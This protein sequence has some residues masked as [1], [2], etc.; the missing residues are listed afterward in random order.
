MK[1]KA[2][3][4][5]LAAVLAIS[6]IPVT[7]PAKEVS[8]EN[9]EQREYGVPGED[10]VDGQVIVRLREEPEAMKREK[11]SGSVLDQYETE[12]LIDLENITASRQTSASASARS[13]TGISADEIVLVTGDNTEEMIR[14]LEEDPRVVYAEPNYIMEPYDVPSDPGYEYQWGLKNTLNDASHAT[15]IPAVDMNV[16]EAWSNAGSSSDRPVVAVI[17]SGVDYNHPD[18]KDVMWKDG[19]NYPELT[20]LGGGA[21][22]VNYSG[23]GPTDDPM[24]FLMGHGTHCASI[25][26]AQWNNGQGTAGV[27]SS[28]RIMAL[29]F[30][31]GNSATSNAILCYRYLITAKKAGVNVAVV[32]NSWG[33]GTYDGYMLQSVSDVVTEAGMEGILS[34]FAAGNNYADNDRNTGSIINSPYVVTVG[35]MDSEGYRAGFSN[36]GRQTVD[37]FA[38]GT[39]ILASTTTDTSMYSMENHEMPVQYL[40]WIQDR[41]DSYFYEDFEDADDRV[42]LRLLDEGEKEAERAVP[43]RG[44][45]SSRGLEVSL[46]SIEEGEEFTLEIEFSA[47]DLAAVDPLKELHLAFAG[48]FDGAMKEEV[49]R[50]AQ[51]T[52]EKW[53]LLYST[54]TVNGG[55]YPAYLMVGDSNWNISS[56]C[57]S[58]REFLTDADGD[59]SIAIRMRGTMTGKTEGAAFHLDNVGFGK[60]ASDYYYSDGTSMAAPAVSGVAALAA[61]VYGADNGDDAGEIRARIIGAVNREDGIDLE[62]KSV[63]GGFL[64]AGAVF[65]DSRL[66]PVVN[67]LK[68]Q[69]KTAELC[70]YFFGE[71]PGTVTVGGVQAEVTSWSPESI[72]IVL[73]DGS[74]GNQQIVVYT[75]GGK[76]GQNFLDIGATSVGFQE[77]AAPDLDYGELSGVDLTSRNGLWLHMAGAGGK[78]LCLA[79]M[80]ETGSIYMEQY[81][82]Q[83]NTWKKV[84]LPKD[85]I[86]VA[87]YKEYYSMA[88]GKDKIYMTYYNAQGQMELGTYDTKT[89]TWDVAAVDMSTGFG[90]LAVYQDQLLVIGGEGENCEN[91]AV[92]YALDPATGKVSDSEIPDLPEG[93]SGAMVSVSGNNLIVCGGYDSFVEY[94]QGQNETVYGNIMI[95]DGKRW[96]VSGADFFSGA[97]GQFDSLQTLDFALSAT[98]DGMI[99]TGPVSGL[100][101]EQMR[102]TWKYDPD[103]DVWTSDGN[104]CF[105]GTKTTENVGTAVDGLFYVLAR[106]DS[107]N[108]VFRSTPVNYTGAAANP[109]EEP[110]EE[111]GGNPGDKPGENPEDPSGTGE[112]DQTDPDKNAE[113]KIEKTKAEKAVK[114]GDET[115]AAIWLLCVLASGT[116][117]ILQRRKKCNRK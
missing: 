30:L 115:Q 91:T 47:E 25:I 27:S 36:Y 62:D 106:T 84:S 41:E 101:T 51:N 109:G 22:G 87:P 105:H 11:R 17:D 71:E 112:Q 26:A 13:R 86:I 102:D 64:D 97:N 100:G 40:P 83:D 103:A 59:G 111:P 95:Y 114:T 93:R 24:D 99:V 69:D 35:A 75:A 110:Q 15:D 55:F 60:K 73:P 44:Y 94:I 18:L 82:I 70:G 67:E 38:P 78:I 68:Q 20:A 90:Q 8:A 7:A 117:I 48:S 3:A 5:V 98:D 57:L 9:T 37:V 1:K 6:V 81:S 80:E 88:V 21:Y 16:E 72:T 56:T 53:D 23:T 92:V 31:T 29:D 49:V 43:S 32:N 42:E 54:Q 39:Q 66:V 116:V 85:D 10:Y 63:S 34:C 61:M 107:G 104:L 28:A 4:L 108:L 52:G 89:E 19:L 79:A 65:D 77:L 76:Y 58:S 113:E 14:E 45:S 12:S 74:A 50:F 33:P 2:T 46:D 96:K